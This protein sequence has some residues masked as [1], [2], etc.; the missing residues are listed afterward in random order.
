MYFV[1][2]KER[3][4]TRNALLERENWHKEYLIRVVC[5]NENEERKYIIGVSIIQE[6]WHPKELYEV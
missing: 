4:I 1:K 2:T 5:E 6:K 3:I